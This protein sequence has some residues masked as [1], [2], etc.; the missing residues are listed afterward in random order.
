MDLKNSAKQN[1]PAAIRII[2]V[3][4]ICFG[5]R[6]AKAVPF[7]ALE[8]KPHAAKGLSIQNEDR[9]GNNRFILQRAGIAF[10]YNFA[11]SCLKIPGVILS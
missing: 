9:V 6:L 3:I 8:R 2:V 7:G 10:R 11:G 4:L 5:R 1:S